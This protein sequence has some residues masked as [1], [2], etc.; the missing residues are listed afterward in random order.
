MM[1]LAILCQPYSMAQVAKDP[2]T[3]PIDQHIQCNCIAQNVLPIK[4]SL[5]LPSPLSLTQWT[6][7]HQSIW[8]TAPPPFLHI[9]SS[10]GGPGCQLPP[11]ESQCSPCRTLPLFYQAQNSREVFWIQGEPAARLLGLHGLHFCYKLYRL[12][13]ILGE[14]PMQIQ[15]F[16]C[17]LPLTAFHQMC[18]GAAWT[19]L[20]GLAAPVS[21]NSPCIF[22]SGVCSS[23]SSYK[24]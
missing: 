12:N 15:M 5:S 4:S 24:T 6:L 22:V 14:K 11:L 20:M 1:K 3:L 13:H 18:I 10:A 16:G 9:T 8:V 2:F 23:E 17:R 7:V 21:L 19:S